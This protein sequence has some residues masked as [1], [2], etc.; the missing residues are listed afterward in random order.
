MWAALVQEQ[1]LLRQGF[2]DTSVREY[3]GLFLRDI[4]RR[5]SEELAASCLHNQ[6]SA[7]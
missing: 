6:M 4:K 1:S 5:I 3:Q 7:I 2:G